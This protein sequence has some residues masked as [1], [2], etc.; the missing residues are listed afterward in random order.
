MINPVLQYLSY[1]NFTE[2]VPIN[3]KMKILIAGDSWGCGVWKRVSYNESINVHRGLETFLTMYGHTVKN[4]SISGISNQFV[5]RTLCAENLQEYDHVFVFYTNPF[6]DLWNKSY[7]EKYLNVE[8]RSINFEQYVHIYKELASNYLNL[9]DKFQYPIRLIGGHNK[10]DEQL[11]NCK[12]VINY[13]PSLRE[14]FYPEFI[15]EKVIFTSETFKG[16]LDKFD[17]DCLDK[18]TLSQDYMLKLQFIQKEFFYPDGFH[19]NKKGHTILADKIRK[20]IL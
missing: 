6:R 2:I 4:L 1:F 14:L 20:E 8:P 7:R 12:H 5:Y 11:F 15:E 18:L 16:D 9:L 19:L 13:I 3:N 10:I 17:N